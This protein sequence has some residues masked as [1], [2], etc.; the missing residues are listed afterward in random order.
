MTL[1]QVIPILLRVR[2]K[3]PFLY[4]RIITFGKR[5]FSKSLGVYPR[6]LGNEIN[7]V[8][9]VL[10]SSQ[11]NMAGGKGL[12]HEKLENDFAEYLGVP[13]AI[14]VGSGGVALQMSIRALGLRPGE[15]VIHQVDTCS[16]TAMSV[17][18]AGAI[19][20]FADIS[21]ETLMLDTHIINEI[22]S[23]KTKGIIGTHMWGNPEN[24]AELRKI[25]DH[26]KWVL[27]EDTC[28]SLGTKA[29]GKIA[30]TWGDVGVFSFGCMKPIQGGEGG[31]IVTSDKGLANELRAMRHWG[32]RTL[33]F[34]QRDVTQLSYNGRMSEIIAAVIREQLKGYPKILTILQNNVADFH[35][36]IHEIESI[37][38]N[39]GMAEKITDAVFTQVI[40]QIDD[41]LISK[42][43]LFEGLKER[44]IP[45]WHSNFELINSLSFFKKDTWKEW[46]IKGDLERISE[47]YKS[48]YP[49]SSNLYNSSGIGLGKM[50]FLSTNNL[51][52]L[53]KNI[54]IAIKEAQL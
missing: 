36:F 54:V 21:K 44:G 48:S 28:L 9:T 2:K 11:W 5:Y 30:G 4:Q 53:K 10:K 16:A 27:I 37:K 23:S 8:S 51:N 45:V 14:A 41:K 49:N 24:M 19:P 43:K 7:A 46:I 25:A 33:D 39:L 52:F 34:G 13:F 26:N 1:N 47:N 18:N 40:I 50:N 12:I 29:Q 20:I 17:I 22:A 6:I 42:K 31:M 15:E 32:D 3:Y 35:E 38:I